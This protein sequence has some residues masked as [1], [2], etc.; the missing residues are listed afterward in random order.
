M[1]SHVHILF[2]PINGW[3]VAKIVASWKKFTA[4]RICAFCKSSPR[5]A[6]L[7]IGNE[8]AGN[9]NLPIGDGE[10]GY[11]GL[12]IGMQ[13]KPA[14]H[15]EYWDRFIRDDRH[16]QETVEYIHLNP[17]K[18]GLVARAEDWAWSSA[19]LGRVRWI[20]DI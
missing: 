5:T 1:P 6:N 11:A 2:Q 16:F 8:N 7:P 10:T 12:P 20:D 18:A 9:A 17:V 19:G 13:L 15:R 14:W 4:T 3:S